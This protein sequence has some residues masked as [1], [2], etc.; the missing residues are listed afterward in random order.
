MYNNCEVYMSELKLRGY[1]VETIMK[2][3]GF[4]QKSREQLA[5]D[6]EALQS[7]LSS[8]A[9]DFEA[10][11]VE[12]PSEITGQLAQAKELQQLLGLPQMPLS[13][14]QFQVGLFVNVS[15]DLVK[16]ARGAL[17]AQKISGVNLHLHEASEAAHHKVATFVHDFYV[18]KIFDPYLRFG[19]PE[20]EAAYRKREAERERAIK[21]ALAEG[22]PEGNLRASQLAVEQLK[23]AGAHGADRSPQYQPALDALMTS[24]ADLKSQLAGKHRG[25][26]QEAWAESLAQEGAVAPELPPEL[27]SAFRATGTTIPAQDQQGHGVTRREIAAGPLTSGRC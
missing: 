23:D 2:D 24:G 13:Y 11:G 20:D 17:Q 8:V 9:H 10:K 25:V 12:V 4:A 16:E 21:E 1:P 3:Q 27:L 14:L 19:S 18:R 7:D 22:T 5:R 15:R 6:V 26:A